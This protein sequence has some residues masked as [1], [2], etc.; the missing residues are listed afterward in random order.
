MAPAN[1]LEHAKHWF[2][3][4]SLIFC[5][6]V[7]SFCILCILLY[8]ILYY[9]SCKIDKVNL[10]DNIIYSVIISCDSSNLI[11]NL[12]ISLSFLGQCSLAH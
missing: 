9:S 2:L 10:N 6:T 1:K 11:E 8:I 5:A 7:N 4:F 3:I 12:F